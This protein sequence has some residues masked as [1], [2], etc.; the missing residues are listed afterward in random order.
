M[1][2]FTKYAHPDLDALVS[3]GTFSLFEPATGQFI[4]EGG[5]N[6]VLFGWSWPAK[7]SEWVRGGVPAM[8]SVE[9]TVGT[10]CIPFLVS[11]WLSV[12]VTGQRP[13][14]ANRPLTVRSISGQGNALRFTIQQLDGEDIVVTAASMTELRDAVDMAI[15]LRGD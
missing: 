9:D 3:I 2:R 10:S 12:A 8:V 7:R 5:S 14:W 11:V 13:P 15:K 4:D 1:S 6:V